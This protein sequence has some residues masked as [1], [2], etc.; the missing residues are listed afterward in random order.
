MQDNPQLTGALWR[1]RCDRMPISYS[2]ADLEMFSAETKTPLPPGAV[3]QWAA[4]ASSEMRPKYD[5]WWHGKRAQFHQ[6]LT[7]LMHSYR[8]DL[9]MYYY[10]WDADKFGLIEPDITAWAFVMNVIKP[11]PE[12]GKAAYEKEREVRKTFTARDYISVLHTGN[13]GKASKGINR[14]DYGIRPE[15]YKNMKGFEIFAPA[16][17]F[18]YADNPEYLNYFQTA[19]GLAMS[20]VVSYDEVGARSINPKYEGNMLTPGGASFSMALELLAYFHG[21]ARTLTYTVYTYGRGFADAHRRFAQA[22]LALPATKGTVI[23]QDD[24]DLKIREYSSANGT[25]V[26]VAYKGDAA[27]KFTVKLPKA[28]PGA[29]VLNLVTNA[30][31]ASSVVGDNLQ[32]ELEAGPMEL[33]AFLI[34]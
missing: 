6:K 19:D 31:V 26:G 12:G 13:F 1:I 15:L 33:D 20:N 11:P 23:N 2:R 32:F 34:Q 21:D 22:F 9:T 10:N 27:K 28:R 5:D 18:C 7:D 3:G 30:P 17:Y 16:N 24:A 25:Y 29:K 8:P 14:A 4:W